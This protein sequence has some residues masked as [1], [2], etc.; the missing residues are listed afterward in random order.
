[1]GK[2]LLPAGIKEV[3]GSFKSGDMVDISTLDGK[4]L[5][6]GLVNYS[7]EEILRI[8]G[9]KSTEIKN[10]LGK[11]EFDEVVHGI[12]WFFYKDFFLVL[13]NTLEVPIYA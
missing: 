6:R 9:S 2:S 4:T 11:K 5:A 10:I 12:T 8:R 3:R 1:M 7:A 13:L